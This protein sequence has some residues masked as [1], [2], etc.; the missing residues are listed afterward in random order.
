M[1]S[2]QCQISVCR[3][4]HIAADDKLCRMGMHRTTRHLAAWIGSFAILLAALAPSISHALAAANG[5]RTTLMEICSITTT[6]FVEVA[7]VAEVAD[8]QSNTSPAPA[9]KSGMHF[10][11]CPFC[12]SHAGS[13]ALLPVSTFAMPVVIGVPALPFLFY[14]SP[15]PLFMWTTAQS[16]APPASS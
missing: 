2:N 4:I 14:Q 16:R 12:L 6:K 10:E 8:N 3:L 7:E 11:H 5:G 1:D 9:E 13:F 15:R